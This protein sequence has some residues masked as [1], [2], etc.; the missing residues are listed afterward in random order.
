[1][2]AARNEQ[3]RLNLPLSSSHHEEEEEEV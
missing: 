2:V 1:L 3:Q